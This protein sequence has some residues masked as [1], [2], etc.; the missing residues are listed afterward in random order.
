MIKADLER[1][2]HDVWFDKKDIKFGDDWRHEI[3]DGILSSQKFF[4]KV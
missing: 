3:T 1:R 4:L 2:G